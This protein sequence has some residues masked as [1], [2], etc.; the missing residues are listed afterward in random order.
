M[1]TNYEFVSVDSYVEYNKFRTKF[2]VNN[3]SMQETVDPKSGNKTTLII[4]NLGIFELIGVFFEL[5][6][7]KL[8]SLIGGNKPFLNEAWTAL[9]NY[10]WVRIVELKEASSHGKVNQLINQFQNKKSELPIQKPELPATLTEIPKSIPESKPAIQHEV[11]S[12]VE[13]IIPLT[14]VLKPEIKPVDQPIVKD[15]PKPI[16]K[17]EKAPLVKQTMEEVSKPIPKPKEEPAVQPAKKVTPLHKVKEVTKRVAKKI[18]KFKFSDSTVRIQFE[19][20]LIGIIQEEEKLVE[21]KAP[22]S[23]TKFRGQFV[24]TCLEG[25]NSRDPKEDEVNFE[26]IDGELGILRNPL[27]MAAFVKGLSIE[28]NHKLLLTLLHKERRTLISPKEQNRRTDRLTA[29]FT[30]LSEKQ[31]DAMIQ[32]GEFS[33][34]CVISE[35]KK[36]ILNSFTAEQLGKLASSWKRI[37]DKS[38]KLNAIQKVPEYMQD[39]IKGLPADNLLLGKLTTILP[40]VTKTFKKDFIARIKSL[41]RKSRPGFPYDL[42]NVS[43]SKHCTF[44]KMLE[45]LTLYH[46][47]ENKQHI[48]EFVNKILEEAKLHP[49]QEKIHYEVNTGHLN[50]VY[51]TEEVKKETFDEARIVE[52]AS[53]LKNR[54]LENQNSNTLS[55]MDKD[56]TESLIKAIPPAE[57]RHFWEAESKTTNAGSLVND[58]TDRLKWVFATLSVDQIQASTKSEAF[59]KILLDSMNGNTDAAAEVFSAEQLAA[60]TSNWK[61]HKDLLP[62][63]TKLTNEKFV[64][65]L[66]LVIPQST[67]YLRN[68]LY[69]RIETIYKRS[70]EIKK[71]LKKQIQDQCNKMLEPKPENKEFNETWWAFWNKNQQWY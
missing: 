16:I 13:P 6:F 59:M 60:I 57:I 26:R 41:P 58:R 28:D 8:R 36:A 51:N 64:A 18:D 49:A 7:A 63:I 46:T 24:K 69:K 71:D 43:V 55:L 52:L 56:A 19:H 12:N 42:N 33:Q 65:F 30:H 15:E 47:Q 37:H 35:C 25:I 48:N 23:N 2:S 3:L 34:M 29:L 14:P 68:T 9:I 32:S 66:P 67:P 45:A 22:N 39:I 44:I 31:F 10:Q 70:P 50:T 20:Q 40:H 62:L 54:F 38:H 27:E 11:K 1:Y 17:A 53:N 21:A 61:T 4:R 5:S